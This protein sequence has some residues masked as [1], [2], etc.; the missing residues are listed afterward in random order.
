MRAPGRPT[1]ILLAALAL[2]ATATSAIAQ[3]GLRDVPPPDV[4]EELERFELAEGFE[5]ALFAA[6]PM[7]VKPIQINF[8]PAGRIWVASSPIYP[9][10]LPGA[11]AED[12]VLVVEDTDGDGRADRSTVFAE[13]LLI[14][15]AV[16]PG[17]GGAYVANSTELLHL[18][19]VDGDL[20]ADTRRVVLSGFGTEDT[21][22][23]L[24]T[25]RWGPEGL[26][27]FN[28]SIYIHSHIE[29]PHG[30]RRLDAGGIWRLRPETL[31]LDVFVRGMVNGWGHQFDRWGQQFGADGAYSEGILY[32]IPGAF[33]ATAHNAR[34]ILSGLNPGSPKHCSIEILGGRHLPDDWQGTIIACDFRANRINRFALSDAGAGYRSDQ[35]PDLVRSRH[36]AF[37]PI[38]VKMGPDG[39]IYIADW[40]NP[41]IQHGEVDFRDERRNHS[42]GRIWRITATGRPL[43][44]RPA[45]VG[46]P[47]GELLERLRAPEQWTRHH[48][49]RVLSERPRDEVL[50]ALSRWVEEL[51]A[52]D[53]DHEHHLL[54]ALWVHQTL[55]DVNEKFLR[56]LL[57][58][59]EPRARAAAVRVLSHWWRRI[60]R[61]VALGLLAPCVSDEFARVRLEAVRALGGIPDRRAAE[62]ALSVLDRPID[63]FL[64]YGLWLTANEL[65][66]QWLP[67]LARGEVVFGGD[68]RRLEFALE[69]VGSDAAVRPIRE[70]IA[71]G[72]T[73]RERTPELLRLVARLG[74][75]DDLA[76]VFDRVAGGDTLAENARVTLLRE[77][78]RIARE[79]GTRPAVDADRVAALLDSGPP[80][81]RAGA[82][83]LA[84]LWKLESLRERLRSAALDRSLDERLHRAVLD[85]LVALGDPESVATLEAALEAATEIDARLRIIAA[86]VALDLPRAARR[87][88]T[89]I[90]DSRTVVG[91]TAG[92]FEAFFGRR[93]G[94][95]ALLGALG[96]SEIQPDAAKV[97]LRIAQSSGVASPEL[98]ERLGAAAGEG[99]WEPVVTDADAFAALLDEIRERGDARRG[100]AIY[101][102]PALK[103][104]ECHAIGG[105]GGQVGPDMSSLGGASQL[106]SIVDSLVL[107][108]KAVKENYHSLVVVTRQGEVVTGI[109]IASSAESVT[110]RTSSG[111]ERTIGTSAILRRQVSGSI[112]PENLVDTL[113]REELVDLARFLAALGK[114]EG[115]T[116]GPER[117]ARRWRLL[118]GPPRELTTGS[119]AA[120]GERLAN[121]SLRWI[122]ATSRVDGELPLEDLASTSTSTS[123]VALARTEISAERPGRVEL[124]INGAEGLTAWL[125]AKPIEL[126]PTTTLVLEEG[127]HR[128][129]LRVETEKRRR[130]LRVTLREVEGSA[131]AAGFVGG[132]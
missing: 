47:I 24:H 95:A 122:P 49:R 17:D 79:K 8:D 12:R 103:C 19:D 11:R 69:A 61:D 97:G 41:I 70:L 20:R 55:D 21:H 64:D 18:E 31:E 22:H 113:T 107:P 108:N 98:I 76:F 117:V 25:L 29:T 111:E 67:A 112:M 90:T 85:G 86:L 84:G 91:D 60:G 120:I 66:E 30:V 106:D 6:D 59:S 124:T 48:A 89:L 73:S 77:L 132:L 75:P 101:R 131:A 94:P 56:R 26:L 130:G 74:G 105:A 62:L 93:E 38:D 46:A 110:L 83:R 65:A 92:V 80:A 99:V 118:A 1:T 53:A 33:Y 57:A 71:A 4:S 96:D 68:A 87:F 58:S 40:Y 63:R 3:R 82:Y 81:L 7:V 52:A 72:E 9:Q 13:G 23:I 127:I 28:Q 126:E 2:I 34:R 123:G 35:Q 115:F 121:T 39:A 14:P 42:N 15:T 43:V 10:L 104:I 109:P 54:E 119:P 88:A 50:A 36:V 116:V 100:E 128:L 114:D 16:I 78:A 27:Y 51:D 5:I 45:L 37:R 129:D 32:F 44:E 125:D 102:R